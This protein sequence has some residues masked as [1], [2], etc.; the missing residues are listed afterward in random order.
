M[1]A[2]V[3]RIQEEDTSRQEAVPYIS[4][5]VGVPGWEEQGR[6]SDRRVLWGGKRL[7]RIV[8]GPENLA[9]LMLF[10]VAGALVLMFVDVVTA[11]G[12]PL[13]LTPR[14]GDRSSG[15]DLAVL[16][17]DPRAALSGHGTVR[18]LDPTP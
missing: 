7:R 13:A 17:P 5:L 15:R 8:Y 6:P 1:M 14:S 2:R 9:H 11:D 4:P 12:A 10:V 3:A 16:A 18:S